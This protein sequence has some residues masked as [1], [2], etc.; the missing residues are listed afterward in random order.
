MLD[1]Y[2]AARVTGGW[3]NLA[4]P[5]EHDQNIGNHSE[6]NTQLMGNLYKVWPEKALDPGEYALMEFSDDENAEKQDIELLIWDFAI[7]QSK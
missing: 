6:R 5:A 3:P 1:A 7:E 4:P 2:E